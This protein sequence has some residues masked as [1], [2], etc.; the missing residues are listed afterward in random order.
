MV[1]E[2]PESGVVEEVEEVAVEPIV[3][4]VIATV[5]SEPPTPKPAPPPGLSCQ[6][7]L[8]SCCVQPFSATIRPLLF[9]SRKDL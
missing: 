7:L 4:V 5:P 8:M 3:Q 2:E 6:I 9:F 1:V